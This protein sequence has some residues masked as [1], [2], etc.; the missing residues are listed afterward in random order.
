MDLEAAWS[1]ISKSTKTAGRVS[2]EMINRAAPVA[3]PMAAW[4]DAEADRRRQLRTPEH[5]R[6]L[7]DAQRA[8]NAARAASR[9]ARSQRA[10]ARRET[11]NP[12][13][14]ARRAAAAAD[15]AARQQQTRAL[16]DLRAARR[17]Y[18][19]TLA[20]LA[21]R[22]HAAHAVP[23]A[24]ASYALSTPADWAVWPVSTSAALVAAHVGGLWLGRRAVVA[25]AAPEG[26]SAEEQRLMERLDP[27][28]WVQHAPDRGLS[29]T[30]TTPPAL[31]PAGIVTN[32]RLDGTWT[33]EKLRGAEA[34]V[35][36][37]LGARTALPAVIKAGERGGWAVLVLRTRSAADGADL[38]WAPGAAFGVDTVTGDEVRIPLGQRLLIAGRSGAGKSWSAR[39][40]LFDASEGEAH[41][42]V[43]ID[44][45]RVEARNWEH[46]ARTATTPDAAEE[47]VAELVEEMLER[48][49]LVPRGEDTITPTT[50]TPRITVFV[51]EGAEVVTTAKDAL[52][53][54]ESI[55]RMGRAACIDLWW[56]TQ[57]PTMSGSSPGIPAQIAP[58]LSTVVSLAVSTPTEARTV[59]GEDAQAKGW[60][61]ED[62][63]APGYALVRSGPGSK[64]N[65]VR[66]RA[67]SPKEVVALPAT[68][69]WRRN[70]AAAGVSADAAPER[71]VLR[72]V[73][74]VPQQKG[75][76]AEGLTEAETAVLG[77]IR[78]AGGPVRQAAVV[79]ASG[80]SKGAVSKA[81][82]KLTGAG[83]VARTEDGALVA[84]AGEVSA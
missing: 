28:W 51:D 16:A 69:I 59:L 18:P 2:A 10:A 8:H 4:W 13:A 3:A 29:G 78:A 64:P 44:L 48:L 71:P 63:P 32:I 67:L 24:V 65:P 27:S 60:R 12:L 54:L 57:K 20:S 49:D 52:P 33:V 19:A 42:L 14:T 38:K 66:T 77:A 40:L 53:G 41:R 74:D 1:K 70:A 5:L 55:A 6:A 68:P 75:A 37:L 79:E 43:V 56:A 26:L 11:R 80:V 83:L 15:R 22:A 36:A 61:A 46:R 35:R 34:S 82:R 47:V 73:K 25:P 9:T 23:A 76:E 72:L 50:D 21:A 58:Q 17:E 39:P 31:T 81:V 7:M 62:L 45:K 84:S 30:V